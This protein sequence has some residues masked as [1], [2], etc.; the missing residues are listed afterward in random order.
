MRIFKNGQMKNE[1]K[2][3]IQPYEKGL[4]NKKQ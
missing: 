2:F 3:S 1:E 4:N